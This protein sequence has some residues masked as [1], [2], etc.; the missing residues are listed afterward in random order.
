MSHDAFPR[1][2]KGSSK[3]SISAVS[4]FGA[5]ALFANR[6]S[7]SGP[8]GQTQAPAAPQSAGNSQ[9]I[10]AGHD[11]DADDVSAPIQTANTYTTAGAQAAYASN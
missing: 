7:S 1:S 5:Q 8:T 11:G 4:G 6:P 2:M 3:M 9:E 10:N